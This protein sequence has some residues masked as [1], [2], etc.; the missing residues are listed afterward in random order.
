MALD[1]PSLDYLVIGHIAKDLTPEGAVIGGTVAY[2][3]RTA[4]AFGL[5]VGAITSVNED[6]DL[7]PLAGI[8]LARYPTGQSTTFRNHYTK[9]GRVQ[10][11]LS[12]ATD[13]GL[14]AV[15]PDWGMAG[16][17][18][19]G[20]IAQEVD[21]PLIDYSPQAFVG[22]TPQGWL[23]RWEEDGRVYLGHWKE[24]ETLLPKADAVVLSLEDLQ[25]K[26]ELENEVAQHCRL[27]VITRASQGARLYW[28]KEVHHLPAPKMKE[29]DSTGAGD[30]FAAV[31]FIQMQNTKNPLE[32][33]RIANIIAATSITRRGVRSSPTPQE[34][35]LARA[36]VAR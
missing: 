4:L 7:S 20:P 36:G 33:A 21:P 16:I 17:V 26:Q 6:I 23:R 35:E 15:P 19:F 24:I 18:H 3:G 12:K 8:T 32:A 29:A 5:K 14:E 1:P 2:A 31:F 11:L 25:G 28:H 22:I 13:L 10:H 30:I 27:L 34:I 9:G